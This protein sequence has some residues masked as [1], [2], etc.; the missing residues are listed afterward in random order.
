MP[1]YYGVYIR[2]S[3]IICVFDLVSILIRLVFV[4]WKLKV[5]PRTSLR[6]LLRRR[7][8]D[9]DA[10]ESA[11]GTWLRWLLFVLGPLPQAIRLAS[12]EGTP[13]TKI[14]GFIFL[15]NFIVGEVAI[16]LAAKGTEYTLLH[17]RLEREV[18]QSMEMQDKPFKMIGISSNL[19]A[20]PMY[21][22]SFIVDGYGINADRPMKYLFGM[23]LR[24]FQFCIFPSIILGFAVYL[25]NRLLSITKLVA[26]KHRNVVRNL[27]LVIPQNNEDVLE[28]EEDAV[29]FL[30][31]FFS[32]LMHC[33]LGYRFLYDPS[34]TVNPG[35]T[36]VFG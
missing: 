30:G 31:I 28:I 13:W 25:T 12:F 17:F 15:A 18:N 10:E 11:N 20:W 34:G 19:V 33:L 27:M 9:S 4:S 16:I 24:L 29:L 1:S 14:I 36:G 2:S 26:Q 22:F 8:D 5:S 35:W 3:P 32:N 6:L 23:C 7:F 21:E